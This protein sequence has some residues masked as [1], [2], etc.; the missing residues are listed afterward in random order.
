MKIHVKVYY[1][2]FGYDESDTILCEHC[3]R[4]AVDI[5]HI[6]FKGMGGRKTFELD[7][8][9]YGINDILNL[10]ALCRGCH[11]DAHKGELSKG[12]LILMH[13]YTLGKQ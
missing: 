5:H 6:H 4:V 9:L 11:D 3:K 12:M 8:K 2:Y 1:T 10:I 13:R 7:G